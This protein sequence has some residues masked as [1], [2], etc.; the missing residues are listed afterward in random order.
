MPEI[1]T[2]I[3]FE[4]ECSPEIFLQLFEKLSGMTLNGKG[5]LENI[6]PEARMGKLIGAIIVGSCAKPRSR[7]KDLDFILVLEENSNS[8]VENFKNYL[9]EIFDY[10]YSVLKRKQYCGKIDFFAYWEKSKTEPTYWEEEVIFPTII[11]TPGKMIY[12]F[13]EKGAKV[14]KKRIA[15]IEKKKTF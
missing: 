2:K 14:I 1:E 7:P 3:A 5:N 15:E 13:N 10:E 6:P 9:L 12:A 11:N 4:R 8:Q